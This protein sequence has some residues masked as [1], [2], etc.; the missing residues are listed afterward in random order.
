MKIFRKRYIPNEVI[1]ISGDELIYHDEEMIVTKWKPIHP[2]KDIAWGISYTLLN[3]GWK[4]SKFYGFKDELC[5]WYCD[6]I[7]ANY[8][9]EEDTLITT[10]LLLDLKVYPDGTHEVLDVEELE[11]AIAKNLITE[12][13]KEDA[14]NK[15]NELLKLVENKQFPPMKEIV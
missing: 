3:K 1:D 12:E 14:L 5:Y 9:V 7:E 10:D 2:K 15:L 13:Q 11:D 8:N 6:I 4:I